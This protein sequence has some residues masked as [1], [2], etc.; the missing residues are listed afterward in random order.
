MIKI[1]Y[2]TKKGELIG[3][4]IKKVFNYYK[5]DCSLESSKEFKPLGTEK[6]F[7][8]IMATGITLRKYILGELNEFIKD[9]TQDPFVIAVDE[10]GNNIIPL[11]SSHLGQ[12]M[13]F[14]ELLGTEL[15]INVSKTT[16][17]DV[18][19][20]LGI[21]VL[22]EKYFLETPCKKDILKIN[23]A[24]LEYKPKLS[25]PLS[26]KNSET[27]KLKDSYELT[28]HNLDEECSNVENWVFEDN[29][30]L[31]AK[32][33]CFGVGARKG[34]APYKVYWAIKK[35]CYLRNIPIWRINSFSTVEVKK[36]EKGILK[37]VSKFK[38]PLNIYSV[39]ELNY[40]YNTYSDLFDLEHSE[41]VYKTIGT[42][43]V[44][45]PC[46]ILDVINHLDLNDA[47]KDLIHLID[48]ILPK[49][50]NNGTTVS[51]CSKI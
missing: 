44:S 34:I 1:V 13:Y 46:A 45:E 15:Q 36:N 3:E 40:I 27:D 50:R 28:Y 17:S 10:M 20:K 26:W 35:A 42:Y 51:I 47:E 41:F 9:K 8:F 16:A 2:I 11:L 48:L 37:T 31:K 18:N 12:G 38:K 21:D 6:G 29:I 24:V 43:G 30:I 39:D 25:I 23:K 33:V 49:L 22:S 19:N 4:K 32:P 7:I 14:S 5:Y